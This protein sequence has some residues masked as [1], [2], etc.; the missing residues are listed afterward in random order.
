[1]ESRQSPME[2][3]VKALLDLAREFMP[4][5]SAHVYVLAWLAA[6]RL[7]TAGH[8]PQV[9]NVSELN[10]DT[11]W[12]QMGELGLLL[13]DTLIVTSKRGDSDSEISRRTQTVAVLAEL[14]RQLKGARWDLLPCIDMLAGR[15]RDGGLT[16]V[17]GDLE[18]M[19]LELAGDPTQGSLWIPFDP[20]GS[21]SIRAVRRG[22]HVVDAYLGDSQS[23]VARRL[24]LT[25]ESGE[26]PH[27]GT[28]SSPLSTDI[29]PPGMRADAVVVIPPFGAKPSASRPTEPWLS[30][31]TGRLEAAA[32]SE[33]WAVQE[34]VN[35]A[36]KRAVF[37][38]PASLLFAR[39]QEERLREYLLHRGGECTELEAVIALPSTHGAPSM[40]ASAV[41]ILSPGGHHDAIRMVDL[42]GSKRSGGSFKDLDESLVDVALGRAGDDRRC[43]LVRRD[44]IENNEASFAPSRYL[45]SH[46][47]VGPNSAALG[48][49]CEL[50]RPPSLS[51]VSTGTKAAEVGIAHLGVWRPIEPDGSKVITTRARPGELPAIKTGDVILAIKGSVGKVGLVG[52]TS[53]RLAAVVSQS[54]VALRL[55]KG[56]ARSARLSPSYLLMYLASEQGQEQL[57]GLQVGMGVPHIS[58]ATLLSATRVPLPA[59][60]AEAV[61]ADYEALCSIEL[62]MERLTEKAQ[63]IKTKRWTMTDDEP[64]TQGSAPQIEDEE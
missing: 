32:R 22:W 55:N 21:M 49:L 54:C 64:A 31:T 62:D 45:R 47:D 13:S 20:V 24:M 8:V 26:P 3:A 37:L 42:G 58:P 61:E 18:E 19:L 60:D 59:D 35:R 17:P 36:E 50:I 43:I 46:V 9:K 38:I 30:M 29:L 39:G 27:S 7:I 63:A 2:S 5:E 14:N 11:A 16:Y 56:A 1:M 40:P 48:D 57:K 33:V 28:V 53:N 4:A 41:L 10:S 23:A 15:G 25:I 52:A 44:Q 34:F 51:K 6:A 12:D